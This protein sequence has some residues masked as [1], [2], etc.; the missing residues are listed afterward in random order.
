MNNSGLFSQQLDVYLGILQTKRGKVT[1]AI[2]FVLFYREIRILLT[3]H[4]KMLC[5]CPDSSWACEL[6]KAHSGALINNADYLQQEYDTWM[7]T[8]GSIDRI[9]KAILHSQED[10]ISQKSSFS[11]LTRS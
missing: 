5:C 9:S 6:L 1:S 7:A 11:M 10:S 8:H 2:V 4:V 3:R